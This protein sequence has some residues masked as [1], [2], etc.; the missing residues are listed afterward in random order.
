M[1]GLEINGIC[2]RTAIDG[3]GDGREVPPEVDSVAPIV[4]PENMIE[5]LN[6]LIFPFIYYTNMN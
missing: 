5:T 6:G 4:K 3:V 1:F 2:S